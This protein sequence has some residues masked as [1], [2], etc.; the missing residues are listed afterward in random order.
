V[1]LFVLGWSPSGGVDVRPAEAALRGLLAR[2]P[3]LESADHISW[4]AP[5]GCAALAS[6]SHRPEQTG[7]VRYVHREEGRMA[8]FSGRPF[9]WIGDAQTDGRAPLDPRFYLAPIEDWMDT[10]DGRAVAAR[11]DDATRILDVWSSPFGGYPLFATEHEGVRWISNN[12]EAL[13]ALRGTDAQDPAVLA[14]LLGGGWSL[15]GH[16][17]WADVRRLPHGA[18]HHHRPD[19]PNAHTELLPLEQIAPLFGAGWDPQEAAELLIAA[20]RGLAD[21]PGRPDVVP[22]TGG[23]DSRLVLA[24]AL[25][26]GV[27]F[28][29]TTEGADDDPDVVTGRLLCKTVGIPHESFVRAD[30]PHGTRDTDPERAARILDLVCSGTASLGEARAL[31]LGPRE[32]VLE[33]WYLGHGGE[34]ARAFWGQP[35]SENRD[36]IVRYLSR[37]FLVRRPWRPGL[38]SPEGQYLVEARLGDL[39]DEL[40]AAGIAAVDVADAFLLWT[41]GA[42]T[43]PTHS[44]TEW[45]R[46]TDAPLLSP[47]VMAHVIG[48]TANERALELFHQRVLEALVPELVDVPF[49][50]PPYGWIT[51]QPRRRRLEAVLKRG[52]QVVAELRRRGPRRL[53]PRSSPG[54]PAGLLELV[55][56]RAI[57][58]REHAAWDV[59]DARR[60]ERL[61]TRDPNQL[62]PVSCAH[63]WRLSTVFL[64]QPAGKPSTS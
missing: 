30:D 40:L 60:V 57:D 23:R 15:G 47:R 43:G 55:R 27:D 22:I 18:V 17:R 42:W 25:Q 59:L 21:W 37:H 12:A 54:L 31:P 46:D 63:V 5:S 45:V 8:C 36:E 41:E 32:G 26:G 19:A 6:V 44:W 29:A 7:G 62:D 49:G 16:P 4:S 24:A 61:L 53:R 9:R 33:I 39:V 64:A 20:L 56:E 2:L 38:L 11:Y 14:S 35:G 3:F 58:Q 10:L 13:R 34:T 28:T 48:A 1:N 50:Q 51:V 52:G